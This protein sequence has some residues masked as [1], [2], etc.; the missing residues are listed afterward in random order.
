MISFTFCN[1]AVALEKHTYLLFVFTDRPY[2]FI[3]ESQKET[4]ELGAINLSSV[5][6]D[7]MKERED[8]LKV[9]FIIGK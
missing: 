5:R 6:V 3:Y 2:L 7:Y 9:S 8:M 1:V 4:E